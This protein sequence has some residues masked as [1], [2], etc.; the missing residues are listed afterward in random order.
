MKVGLVVS[1]INLGKLMSGIPSRDKHAL[2]VTGENFKEAMKPFVPMLSG[3]LRGSARVTSDSSS[4]SITYGGTGRVNYA[5]YQY[6]GVGIRNYTTSGT[7]PYWDKRAWAAHGNQLM[8][9]FE[10]AWMEA[11]SNE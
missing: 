1:E 2:F 11:G 8:K 10:R 5:G 9:G 7:G 3:D 6:F 4:A